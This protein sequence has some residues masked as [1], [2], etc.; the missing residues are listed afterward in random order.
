[1]VFNDQGWIIEQ[2]IK[3]LLCEHAS[4]QRAGRSQHPTFFEY[5]GLITQA[6]M[7]KG[8]LTQQ[9]VITKDFLCIQPA[10]V[11]SMRRISN[12]KA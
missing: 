6:L 3:S 9:Q 2:W 5:L 7:R 11:R 8:R 4:Q 1:M 12:E 10:P